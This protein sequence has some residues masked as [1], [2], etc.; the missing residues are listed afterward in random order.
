MRTL[1]ALQLRALLR[2]LLEFCA[3]TID[4]RAFVWCAVVFVKQEI[5]THSPIHAPKELN[6]R[7]SHK[8]HPSVHRNDV[9]CGHFSPHSNTRKNFSRKIWTSLMS[10]YR[11]LV[12]NVVFSSYLLHQN[13]VICHQ[14]SQHSNTSKHCSYGIRLHIAISLHNFENSNPNTHAPKMTCGLVHA[15][16]RQRCRRTRVDAMVVG[17]RIRA[18]LP[19]PTTPL[20]SKHTSFTARIHITIPTTTQRRRQCQPSRRPNDSQS[21]F[22]I[23]LHTITPKY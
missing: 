23:T 13:D 7:Y 20:S 10:S 18:R 6:H 9:F 17:R 8:Q 11:R 15:I 19:T 2:T 12:K 22:T 3:Q 14:C 5:S 4:H 16:T 21:F 1:T